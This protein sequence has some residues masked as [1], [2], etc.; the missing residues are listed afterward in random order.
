MAQA[1]A[2]K[3]VNKA[4]EQMD[5]ETRLDLEL[6]DTEILRVGVTHDAVVA[7]EKGRLEV[8]LAKH[9]LQAG[10]YHKTIQENEELITLS[11]HLTKECSGLR[12]QVQGL[13]EELDAMHSAW[14][15]R[16]ARQRVQDAEV[17]DLMQRMQQSQ[18]FTSLA[19]SRIEELNA[20]LDPVKE[21]RADAQE[22]VTKLEE[23]QVRQAERRL[24]EMLD[25]NTLRAQHAIVRRELAESNAAAAKREAYFANFSTQ[26]FRTIHA[27]D[28][29]QWSVVFG[30]LHADFLAGRDKASWDKYLSA[31]S[32][33]KAKAGKGVPQAASISAAVSLTP[34]G[35]DA[36]ATSAGS[37]LPS[38]GAAAAAADGSGAGM[39]GSGAAFS[40]GG[41][42]ALGRPVSIGQTSLEYQTHMSELQEHVRH[43]E[44]AIKTKQESRDKE[45]T[46]QR[47]VVKRMVTENMAVIEE[48]N[49]YRREL[50]S[51]KEEVD[52][53]TAELAMARSGA[54][55]AQL[56]SSLPG[57]IPMRRA[58]GGAAAVFASPS[59]LARAA[60][61][62]SSRPSTVPNQTTSGLTADA[63][64]Y[65]TADGGRDM[66]AN[67]LKAAAAANSAAA[68]AARA[69]SAFAGSRGGAFGAIPED[70][71]SAAGDAFG[72]W[73]DGEGGG[74]SA[75]G[76]Q[77]QRGQQQQG[78]RPGSLAV[79]G[80]MPSGGWWLNG[81]EGGFQVAAS[82]STILKGGNSAMVSTTSRPG[83]SQGPAPSP[84]LSLSSHAHGGGGA[85]RPG[86]S[87]SS[88]SSHTL[89]HTGSGAA[90]S[91]TKG[92][93][94]GGVGSG[95]GG[96]GG[97]NG[98]AAG[99]VRVTLSRPGTVASDYGKRPGSRSF[100]PA[101]PAQGPETLSGL[102]GL[103][104][105]TR[106][107]PGSELGSSPGSPAGLAGSPRS[108]QAALSAFSKSPSGGITTTTK[109]QQQQ[110]PRTS[111]S[112]SP[113]TTSGGGGAPQFVR[114]AS[115]GPV[116]APGAG[117][118]A[119]LPVGYL[120]ASMLQGTTKPPSPTTGPAKMA[121]LGG[122]FRSYVNRNKH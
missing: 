37:P 85:S 120:T 113:S 58:S 10:L 74:A 103:V 7:N 6:N 18:M 111:P 89:P 49:A 30:K 76:G 8:L 80:D 115:G 79:S 64:E 45:S 27:V 102:Y 122:G 73:D 39:G 98:A 62:V 52:R 116:G 44:N 38:G 20:E 88:L 95:G 81:G 33:T 66:S 61:D 25:T 14:A 54:V 97:F 77:Q 4:R 94:G 11:D 16:D 72:A 96:G 69:T 82:L 3:A 91:P 22:H 93:S 109:Q 108:M 24:R 31:S 42:K 78:V 13:S 12:A 1:G 5:L 32:P 117:A 51:A 15:E 2:V 84:Y 63:F 46:C 75:S 65:S 59:R 105:S 40:A 100:T 55:S 21:A 121:T 43:L 34:F 118:A 48:A 26:L 19:T 99:P 86:T 101:T 47:L 35:G 36:P 29:E 9:T 53:L 68:A 114:A 92:F 23:L 83:T 60:S 104:P 112:T 119:A 106:L 87:P 90:A 57:Q 71:P 28:K 50:R 107:D 70:G 110:R 41:G 17:K 56:P 67:E